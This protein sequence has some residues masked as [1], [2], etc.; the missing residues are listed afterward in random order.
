MLSKSD[1]SS[2]AGSALMNN[3]RTN[4]G[5]VPSEWIDFFLQH[6]LN[7]AGADFVNV[8]QA[9]L[10]PT[11]DITLGYNTLTQWRSD[12]VKALMYHE[13]THARHFNKVGQAWWNSLA[14]SEMSTIV[15]W[16]NTEFD[17]YGDGSDGTGSEYISVAESWAEHVAR[18]MCD[19]QYA[20]NSTEVRGFRRNYYN[21]NPLPGTSH[22]NYLE[23]YSPNDENP[24]RWIPEGIYND[25]I[26]INNETG[27]PIVDD[28]TGYTNL[29]IYNAL[30]DDVT[31]MPQFRERLISENPSGQTA[32]ARALF[33]Q[34]HY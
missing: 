4:T 20:M 31:S 19:R 29:Q 8:I 33:T 14:Y 13:L 25:L 7:A 32:Q 21:N 11:V 28:V 23:D 15:R 2:G 18:V 34:Y 10:M 12:R 9:A 27:A 24:F 17:P 16:Q 22:I 30:D 26:D 5:T 1:R 6:P 3:H